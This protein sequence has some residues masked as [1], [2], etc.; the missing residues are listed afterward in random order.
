MYNDKN[1]KD[2]KA[3]IDIFSRVI[4][5]PLTLSQAHRAIT[6]HFDLFS[7]DYGCSICSII[8]DMEF[9]DAP[10]TAKWWPFINER[11]LAYD[12]N[13]DVVNY[14]GK[15]YILA[16]DFKRKWTYADI[17][18]CFLNYAFNIKPKE[19]TFAPEVV[20]MITANSL[21][22]V[23]DREI[24]KF[25]KEKR[26]L[27]LDA[28]PVIPQRKRDIVIFHPDEELECTIRLDYSFW[29]DTVGHKDRNKS[30][31]PYR[32]NCCG[33]C[34]DSYSG[35]QVRGYNL[36]FCNDCSDHIFHEPEYHS[37]SIRAILTPM[38]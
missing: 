1:Y 22:P 35:F 26:N 9:P 11:G 7:Q 15:K 38:K 5:T 8:Q 12:T 36:H 32:C 14:R 19:F 28:S 20:L 3:E 25:V 27:V 13:I 33:K 4:L 23:T 24:I 37:K 16:S 29:R 17:L 31:R 34:G 2:Y 18:I 10:Q 21:L 30:S 6:K